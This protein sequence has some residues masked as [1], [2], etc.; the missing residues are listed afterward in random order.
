MWRWA[1]SACFALIS[2]VMIAPSSGRA[3]AIESAE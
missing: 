3:A 1:N 2:Q